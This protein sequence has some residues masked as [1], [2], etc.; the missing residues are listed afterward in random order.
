MAQ[1]LLRCVVGALTTCAVLAPAGLGTAA[2]ADAAS[3]TVSG[4]VTGEAGSRSCSAA[5]RRTR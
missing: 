5:S 4:P 3:P 2:Q 1:R